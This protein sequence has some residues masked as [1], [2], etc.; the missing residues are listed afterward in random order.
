MYLPDG[1]PRPIEDAPPLKALKGENIKNMEEIVRNPTTNEL[2]YR[3]VNASPVKDTNNNIIGSISLV[4]DITDHKKTLDALMESE[5]K[6]RNLFNTMDEG[7]AIGEMI[8]DENCKPVDY[9]LIVVNPTFEKFIG[10]SKEQLIG[11]SITSVLPNISTKAIE[12]FGNTVRTGKPFKFENYSQD[13]DKWYRNFGY[14]IRNNQ[15][16]CLT[17]DITESK[18][19]EEKL[20]IAVSNAERHANELNI[21]I[22]SIADG[23][24][25]YNKNGDIVQINDV[26]R[27]YFADNDLDS[28]DNLIERVK[29]VCLV[30][31]R[32]NTIKEQ[33]CTGLPSFTR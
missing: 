22:E 19:T 13:L 30:I 27:K 23:V 33:K 18:K 9:Y 24:V 11:K 29:E 20:K 17:V 16:G 31:L 6:Y 32:S 21:T 2:R 8:F 10:L 15:F 26:A 5:E 28:E 14:K 25:I 12:S 1:S 4:R 7:F 3:Q